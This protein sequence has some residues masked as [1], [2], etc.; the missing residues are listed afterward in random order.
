MMNIG[1]KKKTPTK[2]FYD[3]FDHLSRITQRDS[4]CRHPPLRPWPSHLCSKGLQKYRQTVSWRRALF[5][6]K[7]QGGDEIK[8]YI[9][10]NLSPFGLLN[11]WVYIIPSPVDSS[12]P[13]P[14]PSPPPLSKG[15]Y[16]SILGKGI[17]D[18]RP[19]CCDLNIYYIKLSNFHAKIGKGRGREE[20]GAIGPPL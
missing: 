19:L 10:L 2:I 18:T 15:G 3:L 20:R 13:Y 17:L 6:V 9:N 16:N 11:N 8:A 4:H 1:A 14:S 5:D 12:P 7:A